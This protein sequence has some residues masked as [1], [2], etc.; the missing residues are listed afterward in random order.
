MPSKSATNTVF[1]SSETTPSLEKIE[2]IFKKLIDPL[3]KKIEEM[4]PIIKKFQHIMVHSSQDPIDLDSEN[5]SILSEDFV[6]NSTTQGK[7]KLP[8]HKKQVEKY[9]VKNSKTSNS[10]QSIEDIS[11]VGKGNRKKKA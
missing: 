9:K 3:E 1:P 7:G 4:N 6:N 8:M 10:S 2:S 11:S 5:E